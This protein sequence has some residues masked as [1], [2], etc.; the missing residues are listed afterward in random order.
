VCVLKKYIFYL[1]LIKGS[2]KL[3][4][5]LHCAYVAYLNE[6]QNSSLKKLDWLLI[7]CPIIFVLY[8]SLWIIICWNMKGLITTTISRQFKKRWINDISIFLLWPRSSTTL[9]QYHQLNSQNHIY[10]LV[11]ICGKIN[12][13]IGNKFIVGWHPI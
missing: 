4:L 7:D 5:S 8:G 11:T 2:S 13:F 3:V 1:L 12:V 6:F 9:S 10:V